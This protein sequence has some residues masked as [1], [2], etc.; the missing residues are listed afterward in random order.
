MRGHLPNSQQGF[1][2]SGA[3]AVHPR[4]WDGCVCAIAPC[5]MPAGATVPDLSR[6][7]YDGTFGGSGVTYAGSPT[8]PA[9]HFGTGSYIQFA[10]ETPIRSL[11]NG[12]DSLLGIHAH[13]WYAANGSTAYMH[14]LRSTNPKTTFPA[15]SRYYGF[16]LA[17]NAYTNDLV[18]YGNKGGE[19]EGDMYYPYV[20][21][22]GIPYGIVCVPNA[23]N[24]VVVL[25]HGAE[26]YG[27]GSGEWTQ[28]C[29]M[30]I[31]GQ[32]VFPDVPAWDGYAVADLAARYARIGLVAGHTVVNLSLALLTVWNRHM[33][34]DEGDLLMADPLAMFRRI[35]MPSFDLAIAQEA[36]TA[37]IPAF[38]HNYR[39][40]R[41]GQ[42]F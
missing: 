31:N 4:L 7:R 18:F 36:S 17:V 24:N 10:Y 42:C 22:T 27:G 9:L 20:S 8:G 29:L 39:Q 23:W 3:E 21:G 14:L 19:L 2:R 34:L 28:A 32:W 5:I 25:F 30:C 1:A 35:P 6:H 26:G 15:D 33:S 16:G 13:F 40:R 41:N 37:P 12:W 38:M 11:A